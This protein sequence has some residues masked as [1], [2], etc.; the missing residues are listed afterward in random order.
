MALGTTAIFGS[1]DSWLVNAATQWHTFVIVFSFLMLIWRVFWLMYRLVKWCR[2]QRARHRHDYI[3]IRC[4]TMIWADQQL[5][6]CG[7]CKRRY[8]GTS[9]PRPDKTPRVRGV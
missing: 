1:V 3:C 7:K 5:Q 2:T 9:L 8:P 4:G 6:C